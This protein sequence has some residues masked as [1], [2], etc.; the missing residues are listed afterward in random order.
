MP[1]GLTSGW[2]WKQ[3]ACHLAGLQ[4]IVC[5]PVGANLPLWSL[6]FEWV[7][8]LLAPVLFGLAL[9]RKPGLLRACAIAIVLLGLSAVTTGLSVWLP[10]LSIWIGG[11]VA[12]EVSRRRDLPVAL[13]LAGLAIIL[14]GFLISRLQIVPPVMTDLLVGFGTVLAVSTRRLLGWCPMARRIEGGAAFSYSL[15]AI[16]IPISVLLCALLERAGW[17]RGLVLPGL[18]AYSGFAAIVLCTIVAAFCFSLVT[19]RQT[20]RVRRFLLRRP[21]AAASLPETA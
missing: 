21:A 9:A 3:L 15:Y 4:G 5:M 2:T 19:E 10:W 11:A 7:F 1:I 16:H 6:G 20:D 13:G 17:P 8:Y 14:G 18:S 12:A